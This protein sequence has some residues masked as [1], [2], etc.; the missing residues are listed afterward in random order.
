MYPVSSVSSSST[1]PTV[2]TVS[3][4]WSSTAEWSSRLLLICETYQVTT[5]KEYS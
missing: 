2:V 5:P 3:L 1:F 4:S